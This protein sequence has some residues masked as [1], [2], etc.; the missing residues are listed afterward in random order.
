MS[1]RVRRIDPYWMK[2][3]ALPVT[4]AAGVAA[5]LLFISRDMIYPAIGGAAVGGVA[6]LL[7]TQPAVTAVAGVLGLLGGITTFI[8]FPR[9]DV[10]AMAPM[11]RGLSTILFTLFETVLIDGVVLFVAVLY[12]LFA[13]ALGLGGLSLELEDEGAAGDGA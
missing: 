7:A 2:S 10:A 11:M 6:I 8:L 12:N 9:A 3:P 4:A 13:G 1:Y 5:A